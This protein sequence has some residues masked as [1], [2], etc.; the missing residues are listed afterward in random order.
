M[1]EKNGLDILEDIKSLNF[2]KILLTGAVNDE[3]AINTF[4]KEKIQA[5]IP[6]QSLT[7]Y[8]DL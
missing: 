2:K 6:K 1:P 3:E 4:N 8:E 7:L 5:F